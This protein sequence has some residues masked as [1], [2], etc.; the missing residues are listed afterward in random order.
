MNREI[1]E[2]YGVCPKKVRYKKNAQIIETEENRKYVAKKNLKKKKHLYDYLTSRGFYNFPKSF[3]DPLEEI[4]LTEYIDE[5]EVDIAQRLED[6]IYLLSILHGKTTFYKEVDLDKIKKIYEDMSDEYA[7]L[8]SYYQG[9]HSMIEEE[10]YMSPAHYYFILNSS[11]AYRVLEEGRRHLEIWYNLMRERKT[12]RFCLNHKNL[13]VSH[14]LEGKEPYLISWN[15]SDFGFPEDDLVHFFQKNYFYLELE[16]V[17]S[18]YEGKCKLMD[19][20]YYLLMA[21][22]C[23]LKRLDFNTSES[24]Q[25]NQV[26]EWN[27][28]VDKIYRYLLKQNSKKTQQHP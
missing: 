3:T 7:Y 25:M 18:L 28:Y 5:T 13:D 1:L 17:L 21:Q 20:E 27:Q 19:Y 9:I 2:K 23:K 24:I 15:Y 11:F 4:E 26:V 10:V 22:I 16:M 8:F 6:M 12:L 14:L